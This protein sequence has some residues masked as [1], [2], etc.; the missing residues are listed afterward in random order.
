M[1][2]KLIKQPDNNLDPVSQILTNRGIKLSEIHHYLN[3]TDADINS[4]EMFG[5]DIIK[6]AI[7]VLAKAINENK[8]TLVLVDCD[9]DGYTA[10]AILINYL[11]DLFPSF[12][13]NHLKYYLHEDKTHGL[14]DCMD[15]IEDNNF[16]LIIIPDAA[17]NDY[18]YHKKLKEEGRDIIILD[19]HEAP[20]ISEDAIVINNQ[21]SD[22][23]NKQLSGAGVV[24]QFCRYFDKI[25]GGFNA[26]QYIDL[27][28]L[29]N[30]GDMMSLKSIETKH[31]ITKGF[32]NE[33][34]KNPFIYGMAEK[35]SYSLGNKITPIGAAFYIVPFINS[36][37]R[38][39]TLEEK[40]LL[41]K[42]ML[43]SEAFKEILSNKRG[44]QLGEKEKLI[45]QALRTATNVKSR[46]TR[47]QDAGMELIEGMIEENHMMEHKVLLFLLEPGQIDPN[48]AGLIANKI[49]AK[50]QR[51]TLMLTKCE[52]LNPNVILTSNPPKPYYEIYYRG[53]ARG[54]SKSG[55][56]N[57]KDIC[58]ET[59]LVEY[60]EGHQNA[61]GIS[62]KKEYIDK[63]IELTDEAL[64]NMES[65]P[66]YYVDYI[67]KGVDVKP[68]TILE[69]AGL[70]DLWGQDIDESLIC[71][72]NLKVIKENLTLMSPDKKPTLKITL[73]N[74]LNFIKFGSSQEEYEKL[75]TEGYVELNVIGRCNA[76]EW[77]GNITP[78][79]LIEDYEIIGQSKYNF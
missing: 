3:T 67:F 74:K 56:D 53:S 25:R 10:A 16:E 63:F 29:G 75:L 37:V 43:K 64:I 51:P 7:L 79:I 24:W 26:D 73:P 47:T 14:S 65:E 58:Q 78:Q 40:E 50:Y 31:I 27:A 28:A 68:E 22:Y 44:H 46:Q 59:G 49:M 38:S 30:C 12:V 15:Y 1:R 17:S 71:V 57:F 19:H 69:I 55:I 60:A 5:Q 70:N 76:N 11:Y 6:Q 33:N 42:S 9:C 77:N 36:M 20:H 23:P 48:I 39:G 72:E 4:A 13:D 8:D 35:N 34:I 66:L 52:V 2:Y 32:R 41:F 18:E 54:Y 45:D 21:L 62:I 61:F